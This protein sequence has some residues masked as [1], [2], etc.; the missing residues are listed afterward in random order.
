MCRKNQIGKEKGNFV[1]LASGSQPSTS[2]NSTGDKSPG[3]TGFFER[4]DKRKK[5]VA[6]QKSHNQG[7]IWVCTIVVAHGG[8]H[9]IVRNHGSTLFL[10]VPN[11][12][13]AVRG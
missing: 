12:P 3:V 5:Q 6:A 13:I 9:L 10:Q 7:D 8:E 1:P 4:S 2:L 11:P